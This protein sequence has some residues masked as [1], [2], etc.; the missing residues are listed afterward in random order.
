MPGFADEVNDCP[1]LLSL[2][3]IATL[4]SDDLRPP[5]ATTEEKRDDRGVT[6]LTTCGSYVS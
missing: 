6:L 1:V 5:Q 3:N 4:Q 2:L